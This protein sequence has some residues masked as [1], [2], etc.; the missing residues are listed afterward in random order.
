MSYG[1]IFWD[2]PPTSFLASLPPV[3]SFHQP[4]KPHSKFDPVPPQLK[5]PPQ[6][7]TAQV[8]APQLVT[9]MSDHPPHSFIHIPTP[10]TLNCTGIPQIG[11]D[12]LWLVGLVR[13]SL[14][15]L[16]LLSFMTQLSPSYVHGWKGSSSGPLAPLC[17]IT[18]LS[19]QMEQR[20]VAVCLSPS[21]SVCAHPGV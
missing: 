15:W 16:T 1:L 3:S 21:G 18:S 12:T 20:D 19:T 5:I 6:L 8:Q 13:P 4:Q 17:S 7:I 2:H 11:L 9:W 14:G 10:T